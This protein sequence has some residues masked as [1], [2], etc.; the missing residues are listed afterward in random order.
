[1]KTDLYIHGDHVES[2]SGET[3]NSINPAN[4][5]VI[6]TIG[7]ASEDDVEKAILSAE[8]GFSEWSQM[9]A[10]E[11]GRILLKAVKI[12]RERNDELAELEVTDCGKP[13]QE[14]NCV[15]IE[16]GADVIEY[17]AGLAPAMQGSQQDLD[18]DTF[19]ISIEGGEHCPHS[20]FNSSH[21]SSKVSDSGWLNFN[22][23]C[24]LIC[25]HHS[26]KGSR[27]S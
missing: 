18:S 2:S 20:I 5:E 16:T 24:P 13:L 3:F 7:Q 21:K 8:K 12:L 15:D 27:D 17:Y 23:I 6:A 4:G 26:G 22:H 1:M 14:A 11:R 10:F 9:S 25:Q 19:F